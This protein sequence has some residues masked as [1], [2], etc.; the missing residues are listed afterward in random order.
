MFKKT[1]LAVA[2]VSGFAI[3]TIEL[4]GG[5][6]LA[7]YFGS[8]V[9]VWGSIITV[10][11]LALSIGYLWGGKLSTS[12]PNPL[13][14]SLF[15]IAA[16]IMVFPV[17]KFANPI[18]EFVF[19][20]VEDPRYGSLLAAV[21]MYF[22]PTCILGMISPYSVRLL[23]DNQAHSGQVAGQLYF[24]STL[25]SALGT[26]MTSFYLVLWF[27]VNQILLGAVVA[28]ML[29]GISVI[30]VSKVFLGPKEN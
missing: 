17:I 6:I 24:I 11:M 28:L 16:A 1:V 22:I 19:M 29:A 13:T 10:F 27:E 7:P 18:M 8:S 15:F 3:M 2:F 26:L 4:L 9:Y 12:N 30:L 14:Y 20:R 23:V 25:G 5:R 21:F